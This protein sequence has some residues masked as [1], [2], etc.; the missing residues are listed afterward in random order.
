M[1]DIACVVKIHVGDRPPCFGVMR[2]ALEHLTAPVLSLLWDYCR[3]AVEGS[4]SLLCWPCLYCGTIVDR[5]LK[6]VSVCCVSLVFAMGL[7]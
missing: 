7:L 2:Q 1:D 5:Q 6:A 4:V 3:Q